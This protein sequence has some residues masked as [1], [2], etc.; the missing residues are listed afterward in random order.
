MR[1]PWPTKIT[2]DKAC[3]AIGGENKH[4]KMLGHAG[5]NKAAG[6]FKALRNDKGEQD[7]SCWKCPLW[8]KKADFFPA[9]GKKACRSLGFKWEDDPFPEPGIFDINTHFRVERDYKMKIVSKGIRLKRDIDRQLPFSAAVIDLFWANGTDQGIL[10]F[11]SYLSTLAAGNN[12]IK[13]DLKS[14]TYALVQKVW[15][16]KFRCVEIL[17]PGLPC[18]SNY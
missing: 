7:P 5:C 16:G 14:E 2:G 3:W 10:D 17:L 1:T 9:H 11:N 4:A 13:K 6:E 18:R 12:K 15:E 8:S